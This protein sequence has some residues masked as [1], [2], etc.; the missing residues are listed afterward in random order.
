MLLTCTKDKSR[1][2]VGRTVVLVPPRNTMQT[3][4]VCGH[5]MRG[6][7]RLMLSDWE[8]TRP[9]CGTR[10]DRNINAGRNI[11]AKGLSLLNGAS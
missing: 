4:S 2:L 5:V 10:H 11:L 3:Y 7:G 8:W 1:A 9:E 6:N